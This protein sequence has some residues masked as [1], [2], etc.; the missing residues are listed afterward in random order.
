M[1][2]KYKHLDKAL[3][4]IR[5]TANQKL[6]IEGYISESEFREIILKVMDLDWVNTGDPWVGYTSDREITDD[7]ILDELKRAAMEHYAKV[8]DKKV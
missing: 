4:E 2:A 7:D 5:S 6:A 3:E 1:S 8:N